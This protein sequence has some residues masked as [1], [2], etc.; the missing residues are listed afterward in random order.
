MAKFQVAIIVVIFLIV[1]NQTNAE[2]CQEKIRVF[3]ECSNLSPRTIHQN[4]PHARHADHHWEPVNDTPGCHVA[5]CK[6]GSTI[7]GWH[8]CGRGKC[9]LFGCNCDG[10][11]KSNLP[12]NSPEEGLRLFKA[13][14]NITDAR[15]EKVS[16]LT[17]YI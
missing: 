16:A 5:I 6:D 11:C 8:Y 9:N 12:H 4:I 15:I 7:S 17:T 3:F 10:G 14:Y 2:C 1:L 13:N